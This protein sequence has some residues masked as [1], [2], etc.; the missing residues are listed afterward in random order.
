[1]NR[2]MRGRNVKCPFDC[3][4][5]FAD[6]DYETFGH[7]I[8]TK[9]EL[10]NV[11]VIQPFC[12]YDLFTFKDWKSELEKYIG[13]GKIISFAT[14]VALSEEKVKEL[15]EYDARLKEFGAF[16]HVGVS[17]TSIAYSVFVE[18]YAPEPKKRI[19]GLKWLHEYGI[20]TSV[21]LR[22][23]LPII[24]KE[25]I[26]Y[27]VDATCNYCENY[28]YGPL[29]LND[30]IKEFLISKGVDV[31]VRKEKHVAEWMKNRPKKEIIVSTDQERILL[32]YCGIKKKKAVDSNTKALEE[33]KKERKIR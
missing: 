12:D 27:I 5:C 19:L 32:E 4:Y 9:E 22:P 31:E 16:L 6:D 26:Q 1:M 10:K 23:M 25:E 24:T 28:I 2:I 13:Y 18:P 15:S 7:E 14:K 3:I 21:I 20:A 17:I 30:R 8:I 33:I 29:Y 11:D